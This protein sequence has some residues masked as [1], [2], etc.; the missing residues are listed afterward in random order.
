MLAFGLPNVA[1]A[2]LAAG[3]FIIVPLVG[4]YLAYLP[5]VLTCLVARPD[6][7][8]VLLVA[9]VIVQGIYMNLISPRIMA[10]AVNMHPVATLASILVFGQLWGFWGAFFGIPIAS[11][12]GMLARPTMQLVHDYLNPSVDTRPQSQPPA[13][14]RSQSA[15]TAETAAIVTQA[16]APAIHLDSAANEKG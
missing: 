11:T 6:Q 4:N 12:I 14:A 1:I 13:E 15:R 16:L 2:S 10:K 5:P 7:T 8:W 9:V 3:L